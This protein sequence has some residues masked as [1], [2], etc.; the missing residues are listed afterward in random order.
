MGGILGV[1]LLIVVLLNVVKLEEANQLA[2]VVGSIAAVVGLAVSLRSM[3]RRGHVRRHGSDL[4]PLSVQLE[5]SLRSGVGVSTFVEF[6]NTGDEVVSIHWLDTEGNRVLYR[7]LDPGESYE[8]QT[9]VTHPWLVCGEQAGPIAIFQPAE[10]RA[11]ALI[12]Y[13]RSH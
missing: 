12:T 8:Q 4:Q 7:R 1:A 11:R 6:V 3:P 5:G 9:F 2:G 10:T 13:R